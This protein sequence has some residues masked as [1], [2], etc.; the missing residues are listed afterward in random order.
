MKKKSMT[1]HHRKRTKKINDRQFSGIKMQKDEI[2]KKINK[3]KLKNKAPAK[4]SEVVKT[5]E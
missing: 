5:S 1:R 3:K 4:P 2:E